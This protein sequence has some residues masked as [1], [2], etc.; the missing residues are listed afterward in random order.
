VRLTVADF[1]ELVQRFKALINERTGKSFPQDPNE[2]LW[3]AIGAVFG[4]WMNDR[5]I[6]YRRKYGIPHEWG[7]AGKEDTQGFL[8]TGATPARRESHS[9]ATGPLGKR[10]STANTSSTRRAKTWSQ[11]CARRIRSQTWRKKCPPR[12]MN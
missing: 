6:V 7:T 5:A 11:V 12:T 10:S 3:G 9:P 4:S 1:K 2:Q 8:K